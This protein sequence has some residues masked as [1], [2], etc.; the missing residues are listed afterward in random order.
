[1]AYY[2]VAHLLQGGVVEGKE[3]GPLGIK[4]ED[5]NKEAWDYVFLLS[6]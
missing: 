3:T 1:M 6:D 2:T 4:P 5:M